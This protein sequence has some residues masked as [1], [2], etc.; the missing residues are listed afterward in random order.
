MIF[1]S[2]LP[3][4]LFY[5]IL[6][7][8]FR[9]LKRFVER[10]I[11][12]FLSILVIRFYTI[13]VFLAASGP[14]KRKASKTREKT[15]TINKDYKQVKNVYNP[16]TILKGKSSKSDKTKGIC[17]Y[18]FYAMIELRSLLNHS[19]IFLNLAPQRS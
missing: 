14:S 17:T 5:L 15:H 6:A 1:F 12:D 4:R 11:V 18:N 19:S 3:I 13:V 10:S 2:E 16:Y 9:N 7:C 8:I